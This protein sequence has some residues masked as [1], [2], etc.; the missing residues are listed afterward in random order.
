MWTKR[1]DIETETQKCF[2]EVCDN[3]PTH[4]Y[5]YYVTLYLGSSMF[6]PRNSTILLMLVGSENIGNTHILQNSGEDILTPSSVRSFLITTESSLGN[7]IGV[8]LLCR[9]ESS[10]LFKTTWH[11]QRIVVRDLEINEC[12][13]V[14]CNCWIDENSDQYFKVASYKDLHTFYRLFRF[15][16]ENYLRDR[17]LWVS[18]FTMRSWQKE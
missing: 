16:S 7:V 13:F 8:R 2:I 5:R 9:T 18:M 3:I 17:H 10:R 14:L 6:T 4:N 15:K 1:I 11:L 12:C